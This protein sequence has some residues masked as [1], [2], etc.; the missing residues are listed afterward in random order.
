MGPSLVSTILGMYNTRPDPTEIVRARKESWQCSIRM[1]Q[2]R[3]RL[4]T[5]EKLVRLLLEFFGEIV[6]IDD[7]AF[8]Q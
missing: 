7:D 4:M 6:Q 1:I 5:H 2:G 3:P 8:G